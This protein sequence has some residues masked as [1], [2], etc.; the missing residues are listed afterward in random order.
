MFSGGG[1]L[2]CGTLN[3]DEE[4]NEKGPSDVCET[5][6][7]AEFEVNKDGALGSVDG[8]LGEVS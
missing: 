8:R 2:T 6:V 7:N 4:P 3:N 5:G 1:E